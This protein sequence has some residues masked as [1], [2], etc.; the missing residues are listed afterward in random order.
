L[1]SF[2]VRWDFVKHDFTESMGAR[3]PTTMSWLALVQHMIHATP[4]VTFLLILS[5]QV[6]VASGS[7]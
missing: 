7:S 4:C 1:E 2:H 3:H 5:F 6:S